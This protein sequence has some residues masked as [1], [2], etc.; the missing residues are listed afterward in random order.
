MY[1]CFIAA[2]VVGGVALFVQG[3]L[4][5]DVLVTR[6]FHT[7]FGPHPHWAVALTRTASPLRSFWLFQSLADW[8]SQRAPDRL[9]FFLRWGISAH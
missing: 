5:G 3:P 8:P 6:S 9:Q 2:L 7:W 4:P 1:F